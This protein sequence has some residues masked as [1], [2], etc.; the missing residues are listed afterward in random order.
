MMMQERT[1]AIQSVRELLQRRTSP[2]AHMVVLAT[3]TA[4]CGFLSSFVLL[5]AGLHSMAI[6]YPI[7]VGL[8]YLVFIGLVALWLRRYRLRARVRPEG[9]GA[10]VDLDVLDV[11]LDQLWS[12]VPEPEV[13]TS[14]FG[15]GGG[16]SG[17]GGGSAWGEG[18]TSF[19]NVAH[20]SLS[21]GASVDGHGDF[22]DFD[23][24][25]G[26]LWL[27]PVLIV[28]AIVLGGVIWV[29]YVA[30]I[31]LAELLLDAGLSA[32]LYKRLMREER[33]SWLTTAV[34]TTWIPAFLVAVMLSVAGTI[35]HMVYPD[36]TSIGIVAKHLQERPTAPSSR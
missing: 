3:L 4:A 30:P 25:E 1:R 33:R 2:R 27:I 29:V 5:R 20:A 17:A 15:G 16:F 14:G 13:E 11:P 7:A 22:G 18:P 9:K 8:A 31:L 6:R 34:S 36:A 12:G 32:G 21:H 10:H 23:V 26:A 24:G 19:S 35:M 28:G